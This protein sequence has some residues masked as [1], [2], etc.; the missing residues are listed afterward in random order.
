MS[1][2]QFSGW[3]NKYG[4]RRFVALALRRYENKQCSVHDVVVLIIQMATLKTNLHPIQITID[5][6][7][8]HNYTLCT[9]K[10]YIPTFSN[11]GI[12]TSFSNKFGDNE[13]TNLRQN[14]TSAME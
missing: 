3:H 6:K 7:S 11:E 8:Y 1:T 14:C 13:S 4:A 12:D 9:N 5:D 2:C 10:S